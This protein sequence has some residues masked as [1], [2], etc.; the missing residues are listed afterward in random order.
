MREW[1]Y[2][3]FH[4]LHNDGNLS[5]STGHSSWKKRAGKALAEDK[6]DHKRLLCWCWL[7]YQTLVPPAAQQADNVFLLPLPSENALQFPVGHTDLH[8]QQQNNSKTFD[9]GSNKLKPAVR[10]ITENNPKPCYTHTVCSIPLLVQVCAALS[11]FIAQKL[12]GELISASSFN[13]EC[14][15]KSKQR[16]RNINKSDGP[17]AKQASAL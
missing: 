7:T 8:T 14:L 4:A 11:V 2:F 6:S 13:Y 1:F 3:W 17:T 16:H 5:S 10:R 9:H 12:R 15:H